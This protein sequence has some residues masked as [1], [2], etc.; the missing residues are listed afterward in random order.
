MTVATRPNPIVATI[1]PKIVPEMKLIISYNRGERPP[2]HKTV[3]ESVPLAVA[4][5]SH[6][7]DDHKSH[8]TTKQSHQNK[9]ELIS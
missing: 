5:S 1:I 2:K 4:E 6:R 9:C 7:N 8:T 3:G